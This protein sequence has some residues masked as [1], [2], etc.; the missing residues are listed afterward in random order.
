MNG[1]LFVVSAPSGAGK[2]SLVKA[3]VESMPTLH[4]SISHTTRAMRR[5]ETD[6]K[7]Y[8]FVSKEEF[9][10]IEQKDGFL[11]H[12]RVFDHQYGTSRKFVENLLN[13]SGDVLLEIDW[14][15]AQQVKKNMPEAHSIFILPP[16][17]EVL[18]ERLRSR[19][20]D[21]DDSIKRRM[22]DAQNEI[23]H[24]REF[25]YIVMNDRFDVALEDMQCIVRGSALR[26]DR[27]IHHF[28]GLFG[29]S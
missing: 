5:G 21:S 26:R 27:Q 16:T 10:Q 19:G 2:T 29:L 17:L 28:G 4:V 22:R 25:D 9:A 18:E 14:Q 15:G 3:L 6:G 20:Q 7:D 12:A 23:N 24:C 8:H 13:N 11:E 1:N